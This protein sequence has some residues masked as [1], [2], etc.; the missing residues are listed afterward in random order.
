[1]S[2]A[3]EVTGDLQDEMVRLVTGGGLG[4]WWG[5]SSVR[6]GFAVMAVLLAPVVKA[7][8]GG[9]APVLAAVVCL[10]VPAL[11]MTAV[12]L[13]RA[14]SA[15][16]HVRARWPVGSRPVADFAPGRLVVSGAEGVE[17][18]DVR[19]VTDLR[20]SGRAALVKLDGRTVVLPRALVSGEAEV[21]LRSTSAF[22]RRRGSADWR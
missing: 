20:T 3:V 1:M 4:A 21:W 12:Q 22:R 10:G 7:L 2:E 17:T 19:S 13:R 15:R 11:V 6:F 5:R 9:R 14:R 16:A 8:G 18:L